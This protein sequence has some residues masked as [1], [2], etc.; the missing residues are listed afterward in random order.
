MS[1]QELIRK[2]IVSRG[3]GTH[4]EKKSPLHGKR[5]ANNNLMVVKLVA[6]YTVAYNNSN[7]GEQR[8][9]GER[10]ENK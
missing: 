10:E 1:I 7:N 4:V 6:T 8:V 2:W 5:V 9:E 3:I